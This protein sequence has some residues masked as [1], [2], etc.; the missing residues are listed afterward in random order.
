MGAY[1]K[2]MKAYRTQIQAYMTQIGGYRAQVGAYMAQVGACLRLY[3]ENG[4]DGVMYAIE[5][6]QSNIYDRCIIILFV[7][8]RRKDGISRSDK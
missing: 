3:L 2:Q 7:K 8:I 1:R 5:F 4:I 6:F